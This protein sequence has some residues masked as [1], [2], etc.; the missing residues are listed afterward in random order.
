[1][2]KTILI[3]GASSGIGEALALEY[4]A[5][6]VFLALSGR[7][8]D[9]L[10][11]VAEACRARGALVDARTVD[12]RDRAAMG[13]WVDG[14]EAAGHA[15]GLA[16][17]NAGI[18][19]GTSDAPDAD[20]ESRVREV[21]AVNMAGVLNTIWPVLPH[22]RKRRKG[23]I[24]IVSSVAGYRGLPNAPAYSASKAAV[25]AYGEALRGAL[26][27]EGIKVSV[28]C[29]GY[30]AS[31]ITAQNKFPM[32]FFMEAPKAARIIRRGLER[33]RGRITFPRPM[34]LVAWLMAALPPAWVDLAL[35]RMPRKE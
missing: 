17:A 6:G 34:A 13:T 14:L 29:P 21:F 28:I 15:I 20:E 23:Q 9:R 1:M 2:T 22:M 26:A 7:S 5:P 12:V 4:S 10:E 33:N 35:T 27:P 30:V 11:K 31:R 18:S 16:I 32:P 24:A 19:S 3:T 25:K 8:R